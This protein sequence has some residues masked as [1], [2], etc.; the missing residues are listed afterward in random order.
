MTNVDPRPLGAR[1]TTDMVGS[2]TPL[3]ALHWDE[4]DVILYALGVGAGLA[5]PARELHFTTENTGGVKLETL[6][7]FLTIF[8]VG[9]RPPALQ[10]LDMGRFLHAEQGIEILQPLAANG[11]AFI[12]SHVESVEDKGSGAI[13][14]HIATFFADDAATTVLARSRSSI[15]VRGGGGFGLPRSK[16]ASYA[17]PEREPD[18]RLV[19]NTRPEQALLYRLSGDRNRL[20]SDPEFA[21]ERGFERPILH[22]LSTFGFACRALVEV[23][24][25]GAPAH[26][27]TMRARFSKAVL[28]GEILTTEIWRE[29]EGRAEFR[30]ID[31]AGE[32]VLDRGAAHLRAHG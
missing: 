31:S 14:T 11:Q 4:R 32:T 2:A 29:A 9:N 1:V 23:L 3:R 16:S 26:L 12:R 13:V 10:A 15:F 19:H 25:G 30:V 22:G 17:L 21:R 8:A 7:S 5:D 24:G 28:P 27:A 20:H 6:P 18:A